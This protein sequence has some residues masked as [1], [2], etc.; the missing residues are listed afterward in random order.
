[1]PEVGPGSPQENNNQSNLS[2]QQQN[3]QNNN[4]ANKELGKP[5]SRDGSCRVCIKSFKPDDFSKTCFECQQRVCDDCAS[6]SKLEAE[7]DVVSIGNFRSN[8]IIYPIRAIVLVS[9][10]SISVKMAL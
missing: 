5:P 9:I 8:L 4:Q 10:S 2:T 1:M 6:Y 3:H 7:E